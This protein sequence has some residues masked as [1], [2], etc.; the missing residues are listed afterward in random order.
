MSS[1]DHEADPGLQPGD[2]LG[3]YEI[4]R[5]LKGGGM[6]TV[7]KACTLQDG[8]RVAVK[9]A[10]RGMGA[11]L[12]DEAVL[13]KAV[14]LNHPNIIKILPG[15]AEDGRPAYRLRDASTGLWYFA[16]EYMDGGSLADWLKKQKHLPLAKAFLVVKQIGA[17]LDAA[18]QA[19][20]L[21]LDV[22]PS[23]I[24]FVQD[25]TTAR[26]PRAVLSDFGIGRL[27]GR[28]HGGAASSS[29][30]PEYA[31]P[32]Q[33]RLYLNQPDSP[34]PPGPTS[35][36]YSL[37]TVLYEMVSGALPFAAISNELVDPKVYLFRIIE[38]SP[39][40]PIPGAPEN[41]TRILAKG[42]A[43]EPSARYQ[44]AAEMIT[45]LR[46]LVG[47]VGMLGFGPKIPPTLWVPLASGVIGFLIGLA[48]GRMITP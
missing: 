48:V 40:L 31:S 15:M 5:K 35:D 14:K 44:K 22:K 27:W 45:D 28:G 34:E 18:H 3:P 46:S 21:H 26:N 17:A 7:Y 6:A 25:P 20:L 4:E 37:T 12:Q 38:Q 43:K 1:H 41:L 47:I 24:L 2:C 8:R 42:L 19:G 30:T 36:L 11:A 39:R 9:V 16:M 33:A 32:E 13:F 29:L 10:K 23:N